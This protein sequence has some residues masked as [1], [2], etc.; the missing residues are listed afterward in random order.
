M[1][2]HVEMLL[3]RD[4]EQSWGVTSW[5]RWDEMEETLVKN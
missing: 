3:E 1:T 2:V 4:W 5:G